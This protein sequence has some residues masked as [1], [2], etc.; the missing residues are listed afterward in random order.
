MANQKAE[1]NELKKQQLAEA[2]A[3]ELSEEELDKAAG[4]AHAP[5]IQVTQQPG[6]NFP[7][8]SQGASGTG[9]DPFVPPTV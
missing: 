8:T 2:G 9:P 5:Y 1:Q 7:S 4:G 6:V 3:V